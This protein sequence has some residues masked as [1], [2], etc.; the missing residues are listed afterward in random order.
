MN[1]WFRKFE[2][3]RALGL[4]ATNWLAISKRDWGN[5]VT[6]MEHHEIVRRE[7]CVT[8][9]GNRQF[10]SHISVCCVKFVWASG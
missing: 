7:P 10:V 1:H 2:K 6:E 4:I 8:P 5:D 9:F 3:G